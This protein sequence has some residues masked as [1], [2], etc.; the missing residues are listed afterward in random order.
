[1][2]LTDSSQTSH[3]SGCFASNST[4]ITSTGGKK[5]ISELEIGENVLSMDSA[6]NTIFSEVL[7]FLD[8]EINKTREFIKLEVDGGKSITVTQS[9]LLIVWTPSISLTHYKFAMQ[10]EEGEY[11]LVNNRENVLEPMKVK[12][13]SIQTLTGFF[14]PLTKEGTIIVD[15]IAAS[16]YALVNSQQIAH[17]S[18]LP[19]RTFNSV[20]HLFK[21]SCQHVS[22]QIG[23]HWYAKLLYSIKNVFLPSDWIY[24]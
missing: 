15:S 9:H 24:H 12:H 8:R 23:V 7:M 14:A 5:L 21:N 10:V 19:I 22:K 18:F 2:K 17:W 3:T 6:G 11:L 16:C 13:K 4:I 1:M 20:Y